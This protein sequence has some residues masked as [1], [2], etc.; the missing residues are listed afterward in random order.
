MKHFD[1]ISLNEVPKIRE[2]TSMEYRFFC[3]CSYFLLLLPQSRRYFN[4]IGGFFFQMMEP[5]K[6]QKQMAEKQIL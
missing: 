3:C 1:N 4:G 6:R 2:T 5:I